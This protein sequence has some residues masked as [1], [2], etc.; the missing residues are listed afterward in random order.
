MRAFAQ[1]QRLEDLTTGY[2]LD[3]PEEILKAFG[4]W[5]RP[6]NAFAGIDDGDRLLVF[7]VCSG[8]G[9]NRYLY[10]VVARKSL[11]RRTSRGRSSEFDYVAAGEWKAVALKGGVFRKYRTMTPDAIERAWRLLK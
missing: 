7:D 9:R 1:E 10:T 11:H 5:R 6:R 8:W 3:L 4:S 2:A